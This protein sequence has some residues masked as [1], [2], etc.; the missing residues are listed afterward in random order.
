MNVR[1]RLWLPILLSL[2]ISLMA[3]A[4]RSQQQ[5]QSARDCRFYMEALSKDEFLSDKI[6]IGDWQTASKCLIEI[7]GTLKDDIR[8]NRRLD[9]F[10]RATGGLRIIIGDSERPAQANRVISWIRQNAN[11][12]MASSLAYGA[13][14]GSDNARL[15]SVLV[16]G[17]VVDNR[18]VC[19][20]IDHLYDPAIKDIRPTPENSAQIRGRANLL[21][22]VAVVAPWA[23]SENYKNI[24]RVFEEVSKSVGENQGNYELKGTYDILKKLQERLEYQKNLPH[25]PMRDSIPAEHALC[26]KYTPTWAGKRLNYE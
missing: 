22:I 21:A 10:I 4:A 3:G 12:D 13:R 6:L 24:E 1:S 8:N 15:N 5:Q 25:P 9:Q 18:T 17:N 20:P 23:Y 7:I 11:L 26:K 14:S 19:V 2:F 16:F